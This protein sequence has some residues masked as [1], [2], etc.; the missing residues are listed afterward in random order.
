[1]NIRVLR[2]GAIA[3]ILLDAP[4]LNSFNTAMRQSL[5][6]AVHDIDSDP[7]IRVAVITGGER[8][9]A[10]GADI[11]GLAEMDFDSVTE[12]NGRLQASFTSV[13]ELGIPVVAAMNGYALGGGLELALCADYRIAAD[14][15]VLGLPEVTLGIMPG[16]GGTQRLAEIV[17]RSRAKDIIMTGRRV[18][19]AEAL[20][21]GIVDE[22]VPAA[23]VQAR[24]RAFAGQL[25]AGPRLA[26]RSIKQAVDHAAG[27]HAEGLTL[28]RS[29][30]A[31]LFTTEDREIGMKSFLE[32]GPGKARFI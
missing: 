31:R 2:D 27:S 26:L 11:K 7:D 3:T 24:A 1:M 14:D 13:A 23:Q 12:W 5:E 10:A 32:N 9:F 28:E 17:G 16:S 30:I 6:D 18:K 15:A 25:A 22:V 20:S 8:V 4:P 29:L 19:S 21:L